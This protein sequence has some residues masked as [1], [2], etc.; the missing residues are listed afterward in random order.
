AAAVGA[1]AIEVALGSAAFG[2]VVVEVSIAGPFGLT[3]E[4]ALITDFPPAAGD[5]AWFAAFESDAV[6]MRETVALAGEEDLLGVGRDGEVRGSDPV[7]FVLLIDDGRLAGGRVPGHDLR[8]LEIAMDLALHHVARVRGPDRR[9]EGVSLAGPCTRFHLFGRTA[10]G[11]RDVDAR[12]AGLIAG[13]RPHES[14][15]G[16]ETSGEI[17]QQQTPPRPAPL[18]IEDVGTVRRPAVCAEPPLAFNLRDL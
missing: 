9:L 1:N 8:L 2:G 13:E 18:G 4:E 12:F 16:D 7:G 14:R 3:A 6:E 11:C 10:L 5:L 15:G 17:R